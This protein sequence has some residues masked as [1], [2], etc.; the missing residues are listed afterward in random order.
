MASATDQF[1]AHELK[2]CGLQTL[3]H[4]KCV[5]GQYLAPKVKTPFFLVASQYD[6]WQ[7]SHLVHNYDGIEKQP[8]Y[9]SAQTEYVEAFAQLTRK[10]LIE[11]AAPQTFF[12][13]Q[14]HCDGVLP[15]LLR[16]PRIR[17]TVIL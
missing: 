7:L 16:T 17:E 9:T 1:V 14:R 12:S 3:E 13:D 4:W 15:C 2:S 8:T 11:L 10:K 5:F 6:S